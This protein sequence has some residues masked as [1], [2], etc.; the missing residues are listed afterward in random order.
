MPSE[1]EW[2]QQKVHDRM[3]HIVSLDDWRRSAPTAG[4]PLR[5]RH[6]GNEWFRLQGRPND[7]ESVKNGA[8]VMTQDGRITGYSGIPVCLECDDA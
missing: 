6:C 8:V 3:N 2:E 1:E 7:P 4:Q 5:C